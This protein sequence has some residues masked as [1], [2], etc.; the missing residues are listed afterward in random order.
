MKVGARTDQVSPGVKQRAVQVKQMRYIYY[1]EIEGQAE[2][3]KLDDVEV[4]EEALTGEQA[5]DQNGGR[6]KL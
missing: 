2:D 3:E 6:G 1:E 4:E 5:F